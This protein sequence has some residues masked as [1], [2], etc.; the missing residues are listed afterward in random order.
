MEE[1][2]KP[3]DKGQKVHNKVTVMSSPSGHSPRSRLGIRDL[4]GCDGLRTDSQELPWKERQDQDMGRTRSRTGST[5]Q[6]FHVHA[7]VANASI[8]FAS[9]A[10]RAQ[11]LKYSL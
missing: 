5:L 6:H 3:R 1:I 8:L 4:C 9:S 11:L 7:G 10:V 2:G